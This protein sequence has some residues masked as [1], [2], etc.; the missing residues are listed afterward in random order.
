LEKSG[1]LRS[2]KAE[3]VTEPVEEGRE[4]EENRED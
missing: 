2:E 3:P 1:R 4:D